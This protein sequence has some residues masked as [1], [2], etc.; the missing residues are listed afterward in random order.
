MNSTFRRLSLLGAFAALIS[1]AQASVP[2]Q[3]PDCNC[4]DPAYKQLILGY[5]MDNISTGTYASIPP[6]FTSPLLTA[7]N[8]QGPSGVKVA[9]A[10]GAGNQV[11]CFYGFPSNG[12]TGTIGF[13]LEYTAAQMAEFCGLTFKVASEGDSYKH[14]PTQLFVDIFANGTKVWQSETITLTPGFGNQVL[15]D[16]ANP[17]GNNTDGDGFS[18]TGSDFSWRQLTA[19]DSLQFSIRASGANSSMNGIDIDSVNV[20]ACVVPEPGSALLLGSVGFLT[21]LR[22]RRNLS[23]RR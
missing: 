18:F 11:G 21:V 19:G 17:D 2:V 15:F 23:T 13:K 14:G 4:S 16:I 1:Q 22:R 9:A 12:S 8:I 7:S 10:G 6:S 3:W 20:T 5:S